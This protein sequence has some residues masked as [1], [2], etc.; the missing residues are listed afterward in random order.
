MELQLELMS[1]PH[2]E[3]QMATKWD[4]T[5]EVVMDGKGGNQKGHELEYQL[6]NM[7]DLM[8]VG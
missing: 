7:K 4:Q 5:K 2:S 6:V 3:L 1:D 8:M